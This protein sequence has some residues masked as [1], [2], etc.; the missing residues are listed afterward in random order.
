M[1]LRQGPVMF[2]LQ[3]LLFRSLGSSCSFKPYHIVISQLSALNC[4]NGKIQLL[5][6]VLEFHEKHRAIVPSV[7][8]TL[9]TLLNSSTI[10]HPRSLK[11][12]LLYFEC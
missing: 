2:M 12:F 1:T 5:V 3:K 6:Y 8:D 4:Q 7:E 9:S 11:Y 10:W